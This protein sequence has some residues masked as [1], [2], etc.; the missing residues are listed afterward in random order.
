LPFLRYDTGDIGHIIDE[1]CACGRGHRLLKEILGR[2]QEMLQ[3][4]EGKFIHGEFFTHIFWEIAGVKEFQVVQQK[5]DELTI[6]I[7][8]DDLFDDRQLEKIREYIRRRSKGWNIEFRFV[9]EID[10]TVAGKYK[11]VINEMK[12]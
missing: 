11:F 5:L 9:D 2:E 4:P 6:R 10:K 12:R 1:T 7:V 8:L 3:T